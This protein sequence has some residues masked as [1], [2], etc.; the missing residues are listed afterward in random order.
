MNQILSTEI[1]KNKPKT[2][3]NTIDIKKIIIFFSIIIIIT[4]IVIAVKGIIKTSENMNNTIEV[5]QTAPE[6]EM[7]Q[8]DEEVSLV[9]NHDKPIIQ[10][11]YNWND[12]KDVII[13]GNN[14]TNITQTI[15]LPDGTN[16]LIVKVTDEIQS[17][18]TIEK[19]FTKVE[20]EISLAFTLI[21][22]NSK[23]KVEATDTQ[24]MAFLTYKWNNEE[25]VKVELEENVEDKKTLEVD[26]EI[27][28]GV[29]SLTVIATNK[30]GKTKNKTQKIEG[31]ASPEIL[32]QQ[33]GEYLIIN[34]KDENILTLVN[35][36]LNEQQYRINLTTYDAAYYNAIEGLTV[37]TNNQGEIIEMV[38]RQLM[39]EKGEN[40]LNITA[41]NK[42]GAKATYQGKCTNQ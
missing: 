15:P 42:K 12:G 33:D 41:D 8:N 32:I 18:A 6:V 30:S 29:N 7:E 36:T 26:L 22:N 5:E 20:A 1:N 38:Y 35:Y 10:V 40:I 17:V 2:S 25:P 14:R 9:I 23:I 39:T 16:K 34:V 37:Q 13:N 28:K 4:G 3:S 21:E 31:I 19:T 11:T 24:E 27:P